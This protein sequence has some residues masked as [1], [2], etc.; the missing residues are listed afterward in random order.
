MLP[1]AYT[2][3]GVVNIYTQEGICIVPEFLKNTQDIHMRLAPLCMRVPAKGIL[4]FRLAPEVELT[5][6]LQPI[7]DLMATMGMK[8]HDPWHMN[9]RNGATLPTGMHQD[10]RSDRGNPFTTVLVAI[11]PLGTRDRVGINFVYHGAT[12]CPV[13]LPGDIAIMNGYLFHGTEEDPYKTTPRLS[14]DLRF[15]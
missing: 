9:Y 3:E 15:K 8:P 12:Y 14:L 2:P 7:V 4:D 6:L 10:Y 11:T 13:M 5:D 1:T